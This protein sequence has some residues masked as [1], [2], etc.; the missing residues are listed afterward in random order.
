[1]SSGLSALLFGAT[2]ATGKHLLRELLSSDKYN[3]V[4]EYGRRVTDKANLPNAA[5]LEQ[6][7]VNFD[8]IEQER[9]KEGEWDVVLITMGTTRAAAG[10]AEAF[11]KI[12]RE[13]VINAAK[14][15]KSDDPTRKQRLIYLSSVGANPKGYFL[16]GKS[17]G[18]T[19]QALAN[20][21]Y[22]DVIIFRP[23]FLAQAERPEHRL[24]EHVAG[25]VTH[26]LA[27]FSKSV[28]IPVSTLGKALSIAGALGSEGIPDKLKTK[29]SWEGSS[30]TLLTNPQILDLAK[31]Q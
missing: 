13:Y 28:E 22:D 31:T 1:M 3:K 6:K 7:S 11:E 20:L 5:K 9:V 18:L 8:A 2:G 21:G 24:A 17:K 10:S 25:Y 26:Q 16:Y 14:A 15:A 19:E 27:R 23:A 30:F 4:G 29:T 12:D